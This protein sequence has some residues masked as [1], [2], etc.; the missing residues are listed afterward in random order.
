MRRNSPVA[1]AGGLGS[2]IASIAA[3]HT[4]S[5]AATTAGTV[6]GWGANGTYQLGLGHT[7]DQLMP[8]TISGLAGIVAVGAGTLNHSSFAFAGNGAVYGWGDN[9]FGRL[10]DGIY[11]TDRQEPLDLAVA[12]GIWRVPNPDF[13]RW[14]PG[15]GNIVVTNVLST[16]GLTMTYTTNGVD[17]ILSDPGILSGGT[18]P[19]TTPTTLKVRTFLTGSPDSGVSKAVY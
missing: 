10:G 5:L 1:V 16:P 13:S 2:S 15:S 11:Q 3:G 4:H 7:T 6:V 17:P 14:T 19:V 12:G 8:V 9:E 18:I